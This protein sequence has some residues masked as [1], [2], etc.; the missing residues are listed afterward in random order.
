MSQLLFE[1]HLPGSNSFTLPD[2]DILEVD[3]KEH[4]PAQ[5]CAS[6]VALPELSE[7]EAVRHL[8]NYPPGPTGWTAALSTGIL[9]H[10]IQPQDKRVGSRLPGFASIHPYQPEN[11]VQ[12]PW[13]SI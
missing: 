2:I 1:K 4:I 3:P 7:V 12:G 9:Y 6:R 5:F 10:E 8:P 13:S 11:T